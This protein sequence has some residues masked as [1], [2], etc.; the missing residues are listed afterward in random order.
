MSL[1][2]PLRQVCIPHLVMT[3]TTSIQQILRILVIDN[4]S[5]C[6]V[7][8]CLAPP[9]LGLVSYASIVEGSGVLAQRYGMSEITDSA[10]HLSRLKC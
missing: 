2:V 6:E 3:E 1:E 7:L 9:L 4:K 8:N 10:I 5:L